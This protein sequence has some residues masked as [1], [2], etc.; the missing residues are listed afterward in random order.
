MPEVPAFTSIGNNGSNGRFYMNGG[1][2]NAGFFGTPNWYDA[3]GS[4]GEVY[5]D[6]GNLNT[7]GFLVGA[8]GSIEFTKNLADGGGLITDTQDLD[9]L[10]WADW[11]AGVLDYISLGAIFTSASVIQADFSSVGTVRTT[12]IYSVV[13]EPMTMALLGVGSLLLRRRRK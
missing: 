1:I 6:G 5:I 4:T 12:E 9:D 8:G 11:Q 10:T 2:F 3:L 13:P 7:L